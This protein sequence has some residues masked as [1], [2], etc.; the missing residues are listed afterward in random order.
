MKKI[1]ML[2]T[3]VLFTS[4]AYAGSCP[5]MAKA[6][7]SK[8]EEASKMRNAGMKAHEAGDHAESEKLLNKAMELFKS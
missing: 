5:M 3:L 6:L 8:I 4:S 7:D 2:L 1:L